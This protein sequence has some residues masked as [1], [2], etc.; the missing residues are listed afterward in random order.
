M[1]KKTLLASA[2]LVVAI[3]VTSAAPTGGR[4]Y[5]LD[6]LLALARSQSPAILAAQQRV[7][8]LRG[9]HTS[10]ATPD[11]PE[12]EFSR[13][14]GESPDGLTS[15]QER[16]WAVSQRIEWPGRWRAR[17]KAAE[18]NVDAG[19]AQSQATQA[20]VVASVQEQ[21]FGIL[22]SQKESALLESQAAAA[23]DL[24]ALAEKRVQ[25]GEGREL[26]RIKARVEALRTQR[27]L[28]AARSELDVRKTV[29]N[30]YLLGAL[31]DGYELSGT[32][33]LP[34]VL[35]AKEDVLQHLLAVS[36]VLQE[37]KARTEA[38]QWTLKAEQQGRLPDLSAAYAD[39]HELDRNARTVSLALRIPL[40]GFNRGPIRTA[41][42]EKEAAVLEETRAKAE[43]ASRGVEAYQAYALAYA[44]AKS[45]E[46][47]LLPSAEK[48]LKIATFSYGQGELSLL[49]LLDA[50]R[51]YLETVEEYNDVLFQFE[52]ARAQ[53]ERLIGGS[54]DR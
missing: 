54:L 37:A 11:A 20:D 16:G 38:A 45:Y 44:Q 28:E 34:T 21:F 29:L 4:Q 15:G 23:G 41:A 8:A 47:D 39:T 19:L 24:L 33:Q 25:V 27:K 12:V 9:A 43:V 10:A 46:T 49:D 51:T 53:L 17:V 2:S 26:D 14:R 36:P 22:F 7:E 30:Q 50:R 32:F 35:A 48:S 6:D 1:L 31:G 40:W 52:A 18:K 5:S 3:S 42:A 13:G